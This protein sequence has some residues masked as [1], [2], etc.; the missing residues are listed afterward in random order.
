[1]AQGRNVDRQPQNPLQ[2]RYGRQQQH[3]L[4]SDPDAFQRIADLVDFARFGHLV[5]RHDDVESRPEVGDDLLA[6]HRYRL[7]ILEQPSDR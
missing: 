4:G 7:R 2:L 1:M 6:Q 3:P 5:Q